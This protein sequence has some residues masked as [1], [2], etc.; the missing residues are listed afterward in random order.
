[1]EKVLKN[2]INK[3]I[4]KEF[5]N[6]R[7]D[8]CKNLKKNI[9]LNEEYNLHT[10]KADDLELKLK[11]ILSKEDQELLE[12]LVNLVCAVGQIESEIAFK[13]GLILGV[14]E[15]NCLTE[16]GIEIAFI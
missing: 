4:E 3:I 16:V 10:S 11:K 2:I 1:M 6:K 5:E 7:D 15:L 13:E 12:E 8:F 14:T 9:K